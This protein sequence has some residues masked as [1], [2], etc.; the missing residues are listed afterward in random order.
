MSYYLYK[1]EVLFKEMGQDWKLVKQETEKL[2]Y[3]FRGE[4]L[5]LEQ[6]D[7]YKNI[8]FLMVYVDGKIIDAFD[9]RKH[10]KNLCYDVSKVHKD[11]PFVL[12]FFDEE[13]VM[14]YIKYIIY[15]IYIL[16]IFLFI[17]I[18]LN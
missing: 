15:I 2:S 18:I 10:I 4:R 13:Y 16:Y 7:E 5:V 9:Y 6:D 17:Y 8:N 3:V 11:E 14:K 12:K 1:D